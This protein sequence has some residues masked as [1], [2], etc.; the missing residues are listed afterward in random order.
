MTQDYLDALSELE[1]NPELTVEE[2]VVRHASNFK[3][4]RELINNLKRKKK[5]EFTEDYI[6]RAAYR[7]FIATNCY[8]NYTFSQMKYQV[9]RIFP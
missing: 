3:W 2:V 7:P 1:E 9:D 6:R 4:N 8:A 5:T